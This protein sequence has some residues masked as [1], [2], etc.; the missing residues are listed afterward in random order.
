MLIT[1]EPLSVLLEEVPRVQDQ[2][3]EM[4]QSWIRKETH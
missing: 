3:H 4:Y 2:N 1:A